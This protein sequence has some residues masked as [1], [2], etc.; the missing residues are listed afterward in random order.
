MVRV[1]PTASAISA[2]CSTSASAEAIYISSADIACVLTSVATC[3]RV[4]SGGALISTL[5]STTCNAVKKWEPIPDTPEVWTGVD[6]SSK[7]W[8]D[9]G[10]TPESWSA[11]PPTS[12]DWTP[13]SASSETWADAA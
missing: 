6:P 13:A 2:A 11:V 1:R 5:L 10:S 3:N 4:Q 12:T 9:A 8:Q 7:V